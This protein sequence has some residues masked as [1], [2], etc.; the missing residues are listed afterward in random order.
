M[1]NLKNVLFLIITMVMI[2]S[3]NER[4]SGKLNETNNLSVETQSNCSS[5]SIGVIGWFD[6]YT[7]SL[8]EQEKATGSLTVLGDMGAFSIDFD[9]EN[10]ETK[11]TMY[12]VVTFAGYKVDDDYVILEGLALDG[13]DTQYEWSFGRSK[14][15]DDLKIFT[16]R[17]GGGLIS[18]TLFLFE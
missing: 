1:K 15:E 17:E 11:E 4:V 5:F 8:K 13:D 2:I 16:L 12:F 18:L 3:C 6:V 14:E 7:E 10:Y 9:S